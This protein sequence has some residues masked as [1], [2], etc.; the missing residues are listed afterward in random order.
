MRKRKQITERTWNTV[1]LGWLIKHSIPRY[2][3]SNIKAFDSHS[4]LYDF[5]FRNY[6]A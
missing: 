4:Y 6:E 2:Y 1:M 3:V 5:C